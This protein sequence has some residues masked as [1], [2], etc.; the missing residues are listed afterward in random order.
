MLRQDFLPRGFVNESLQ[1]IFFHPF[2]GLPL[3]A[4]LGHE[5]GS[6]HIGTHVNGH[7]CAMG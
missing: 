4:P 3:V 5:G 7:Q 1:G 6:G 2:I